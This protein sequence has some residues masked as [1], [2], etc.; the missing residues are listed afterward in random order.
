MKITIPPSGTRAAIQIPAK[1]NNAVKKTNDVVERIGFS[2]AETAE[3][4]GI[5][6]S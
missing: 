2:I 1:G 3:S 5:A 6:L 4:L